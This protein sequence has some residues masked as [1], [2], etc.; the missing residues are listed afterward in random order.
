[1][2]I[3]L[4]INDY[5]NIDNRELMLQWFLHKNLMPQIH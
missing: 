1:M 2:D 4:Q 3:N 5:D